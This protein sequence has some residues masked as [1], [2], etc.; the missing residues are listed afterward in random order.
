VNPIKLYVGNLPYSATSDQLGQ[1]F[2]AAGQVVSA[3]VVMDKFSGRSRGF[4][5]V[6]MANQADADKAIQMFNNQNFGEGESSRAMIVNVARPPKE[7]SW[8]GGGNDRGSK[9]W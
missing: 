6:E 5:F 1:K 8:G 9:R 7:R 4:G 3:Q 2:A